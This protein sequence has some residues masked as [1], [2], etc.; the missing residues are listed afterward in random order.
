MRQLLWPDSDAEGLE[1]ELD[2]MLRDPMAPVFVAER[3]GSGLCGLLEAGTRPYADGCDTSPVGYIEGWFVD[4]DA[5]GRGIGRA[6]VA[7]AE[8]WAREQGMHE[9]ASDT[10]ISN[11]AGL[12]AHLASG[13]REIERVI[14][15]AKE[16]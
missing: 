2:S 5:R 16:L 14:H 7:A 6:L 4:E 9:M 15:L 10:A 12:R 11:E 8:E 1:Q 13:Y 3:Q